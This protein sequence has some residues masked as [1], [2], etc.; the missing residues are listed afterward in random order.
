[1]ATTT[2]DVGNSVA[3]GFGMKQR[4]P[5]HGV[6]SVTVKVPV[7]GARIRAPQAKDFS[8]KLSAKK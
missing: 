1:M 6:S 4:D 7:N 5:K 2:N 8:M 3:V